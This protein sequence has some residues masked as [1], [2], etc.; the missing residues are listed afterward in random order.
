LHYTSRRFVSPPSSSASTRRSGSYRDLDLAIAFL[1][2]AAFIVFPPLFLHFCLLYPVRQQLFDRKRWRA[3]SLYA[4]AIALLLL[5]TFV[6]LRGVIT[7]A[8]PVFRLLPA[9]SEIVRRH[10][11]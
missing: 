7:P 10:L 11:L 6:F 9:L 4:P 2:N 5:A 1:R 3:L 8:V